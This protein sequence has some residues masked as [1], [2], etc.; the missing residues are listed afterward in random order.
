MVDH[1]KLFDNNNVTETRGVWNCVP[2]SL[3]RYSGSVG[4]LNRIILKFLIYPKSQRAKKVYL[5]AYS[6][7]SPV[8][9][10][11]FTAA[12][13]LSSS[14]KVVHGPGDTRRALENGE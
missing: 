11:R 9:A 8:V 13:N 7:G 10:S 6:G 4:L 14:F 5:G 2:S 1:R 12:T 3:D